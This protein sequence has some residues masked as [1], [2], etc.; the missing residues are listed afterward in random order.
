[1]GGRYVWRDFSNVAIRKNTRRCVSNYHIFHKMRQQRDFEIGKRTSENATR[2]P[3]DSLSAR[4][5]S[6]TRRATPSSQ[7]SELGGL[8]HSTG[9]TVNRMKLS[10]SHFQNSILWVNLFHTYSKSILYCIFETF[11]VIGHDLI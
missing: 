8:R 11:E 1:M 7:P 2:S 10:F 4:L 3:L 6:P 9:S 5:A